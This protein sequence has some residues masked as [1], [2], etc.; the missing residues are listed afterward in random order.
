MCGARSRARHGAVGLGCD[1]SPRSAVRRRGALRRARCRS[2]SHPDRHAAPGCRDARSRG[3]RRDRRRFRFRG[4]RDLVVPGI[5]VSRPTF[6]SDARE[7]GIAPEDLEALMNHADKGVNVKHHVPAKPFEHLRVRGADRG[8]AMG[9]DPRRASGSW[10][11][12][13]GRRGGRGARRC[14]L[15]D[16]SRARAWRRG[17]G[18]AEPALSSAAPAARWN[19]RRSAASTSSTAPSCSAWRWGLYWSAWALR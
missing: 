10:S 12:V 6:N 7:I 14:E 19:S 1:A 18:G 2:L 5:R 9:A 8:G 4:R 13:A 15:G 16:D 3:R 11:C 17:G